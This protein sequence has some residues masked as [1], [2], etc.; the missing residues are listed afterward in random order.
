MRRNKDDRLALV[1][2]LT[3]TEGYRWPSEVGGELGEPIDWS[4]L[5]GSHPDMRFLWVLLGGMLLGV[6]I[7]LLGWT[8]WPITAVIFAAGVL[9]ARATIRLQVMKDRERR[10]GEEIDERRRSAG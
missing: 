2:G 1:A 3:P 4:A 5:P 7:L 6:G 9:T 10:L 8:G